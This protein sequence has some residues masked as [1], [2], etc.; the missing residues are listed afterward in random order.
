MYKPF[1][2]CMFVGVLAYGIASG[3]FANVMYERAYSEKQV[4]SLESLGSQ[5]R[6]Q[7]RDI[8]D[9]VRRQDEL[10]R[11]QM[12]DTS[13]SPQRTTAGGASEGLGDIVRGPAEL[14]PPPNARTL[15]LLDQRAR[16]DRAAW[17]K[18]KRMLTPDQ[19]QELARRFPSRIQT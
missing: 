4:M 17:Q 1:I 3:A 5:Q 16:L 10:L 6:A 12:P 13:T 11:K 8:Y 14:P 7:I 19:L 2:I 18:V 15:N 9:A